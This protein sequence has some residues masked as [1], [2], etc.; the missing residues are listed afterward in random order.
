MVFWYLMY[1]QNR[2]LRRDSIF[3]RVYI[4]IVNY[5]SSSTIREKET[6]MAWVNVKE[7]VVFQFFNL[8]FS[9]VLFR[10]TYDSSSEENLISWIAV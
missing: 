7:F 9:Y 2:S 10:Y 1:T 4:L 3:T 5:K 8:I 6:L